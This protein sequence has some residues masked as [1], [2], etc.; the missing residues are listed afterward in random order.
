[1]KKRE[2][3]IV[4]MIYVIDT[5]A[6]VWY[7]EGSKR[8]SASARAAMTSS[9]DDIIIPA[10]VLAEIVFLFG[11]KRISVDLSTVMEHLSQTENCAI[12]PLDEVVIERLPIVLNI[13]DGLIVATALV[14]RDLLKKEATIVTKD[15]EIS[16][17]GIIET[18]W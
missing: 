17:S 4:F 8:L 15:R 12:Y 7:L 6:L 2:D 11:R 5:H 14:F 18:I 9:E 3:E 13:H 1:M 10:I 16:Q